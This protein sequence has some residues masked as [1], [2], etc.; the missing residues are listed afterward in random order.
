MR[1][2]RTPDSGDTGSQM[3]FPRFQAIRW[4]IP[5]TDTAALF[6]LLLLNL[7]VFGGVLAFD[8][9][10]WDDPISVTGNEALRQ[11][12]S[13]DN[14][15]WIF[16]PGQSLR[17]MP[18]TWS[19][20]KLVL[21]SFG[22]NPGAFHAVNLG[23]HLAATG[24]LY[25]WVR[26]LARRREITEESARLTGFL[27]AAAW[28]IHPLRAEPVGWVTA[29][30]YPIATF[31][32]LL[33]LFALERSWSTGSAMAWRWIALVA[34]SALLSLL[35]YPVTLFL[36][37]MLLVF[38]LYAD[39]FRLDPEA[40]ARRK[41]WIP[42]YAGLLLLAGAILQATVNVNATGAALAA[43]PGADL[44]VSE[45]LMNACR[46]LPYHAS[47]VIFPQGLTPARKF[48]APTEFHS[49]L[50]AGTAA[51]ALA[52]AILA[53]AWFLRRQHL[54]LAIL[55]TWLLSLVPVLGVTT[56]FVVPSDRSTYFQHAILLAGLFLLLGPHFSKLGQQT[57]R[58]RVMVAAGVVAMV[59]LIA[60]STA[61]QKTIWRDNIAL[62]SHMLQQDLP[63]DFHALARILA[64]RDSLARG[65]AALADAILAPLDPTA[66]QS[67]DV[68][69]RAR[70]LY[71]ILQDPER[72]RAF[73]QRFHAL[74]NPLPDHP[75]GGQ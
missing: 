33:A 71:Q 68:I 34:A 72:F 53:S 30:S 38:S 39:L 50:Q 6:R 63:D 60:T 7:L 49:L 51:A 17:F 21:I 31:F 22:L 57:R 48:V 35:S 67:L 54:I 28:S 45:K 29:Q 3:R 13:W 41:I 9:V 65:Q 73:D 56:Y 59:A 27:C 44:P 61:F 70:T 36:P 37:L 8:F 75:T 2:H 69:N 1:W 18:L 40:P 52:A 58:I 32:G 26:N 42:I 5:Q 24:V 20:R 25:L 16:D 74:T 15:G 23:F 12:W 64:A 11:A 55:L 4:L 66:I 46:T 14:A 10:F 19:L 47:S 43:L 62:L